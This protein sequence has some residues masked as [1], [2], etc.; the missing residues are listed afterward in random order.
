MAGPQTNPSTFSMSITEKLTVTYDPTAYLESVTPPDTSISAPTATITDASGNVT[1]LSTDPEL[2]DSN[3]MA[4]ITFDGPVDFPKTG[5][6]LLSFN[7]TSLP[8]TNVF[9]MQTYLLIGP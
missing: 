6:Y 2:V 5:K 3:T 4:E 7:F 1:D 8:S 9:A